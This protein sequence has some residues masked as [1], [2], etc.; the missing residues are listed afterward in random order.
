MNNFEDQAT[1]SRIGI[2]SLILGLAGVVLGATGLIGAMFD[3][4]SKGFPWNVVYIVVGCI[5]MRVSVKIASGKSAY[6]VKPGE[7]E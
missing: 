3:L 4:D 1:L 7:E 5:L 2:V 6:R